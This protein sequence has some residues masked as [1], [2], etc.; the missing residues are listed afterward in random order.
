MRGDSRALLYSEA[1]SSRLTIICINKHC[2]HK[3]NIICLG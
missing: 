3:Y 2:H 1:K